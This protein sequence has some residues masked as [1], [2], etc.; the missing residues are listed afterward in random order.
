ML[1]RSI[2]SPKLPDKSASLRERYLEENC[3]FKIECCCFRRKI[4]GSHKPPPV[5]EK[6]LRLV[7][8]VT[9]L[10]KGFSKLNVVALE[11]WKDNR[12]ALQ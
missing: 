12:A 8:C 11:S 7:G 4:S 3:L 1:Y 5:S 6:P 10:L 2:P 9:Y